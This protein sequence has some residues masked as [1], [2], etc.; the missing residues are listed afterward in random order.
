VDIPEEEE[1]K[2]EEE[3]EEG[4]DAF[5]KAYY[6][7]V[8]AVQEGMATIRRNMQEM[9]E[10]YG[11]AL[12]T[13]DL[14]QGAQASKELEELV[15]S[16]NLTAADIRNK[17][18]KMDE[19]LKSEKKGVQIKI[20]RNMQASLTK[21]FLDLMTEYQELQN[22]FKNKFREKIAMQYKI[23]KPDASPEEI[24]EAIESGD[25]QVFANIILQKERKELAKSA[26]AYIEAKHNDIVRLE[27]SIRELH[28][29]FLDMAILVENQ[30]EL[31]DQIEYNVNQAVSNTGEAVENLRKAN[32]LQRK[33]RK[34]MCIIICI[35]VV[36]LILLAGG[37]I[38]SGV[39]VSNRNSG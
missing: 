11:E 4:E 25:T 31:L 9:E 27:E 24:E 32:K 29:L 39:V 17:L 30:G 35:L 33:S 5:M 12:V 36:V 19:E 23:A 20:R 28:Q 1:E 14:Q 13:V 34:K 6:E 16:T 18:K 3:E 8:N 2:K 7:E 22:K 15:D 26:L 38:I 21:K 37:G 10:K